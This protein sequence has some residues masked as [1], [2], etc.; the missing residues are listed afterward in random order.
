MTILLIIF[1]FGMFGNFA[2]VHYYKVQTVQEAHEIIKKQ[3]SPTIR[4]TFNGE[5]PSSV[6]KL[7]KADLGPDGQRVI[8]DITTEINII[9]R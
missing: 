3:Y 4:M 6:F 5:P 8:E 9:A 2:D 7:Y 1:N